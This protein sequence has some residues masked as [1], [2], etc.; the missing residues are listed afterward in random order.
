MIIN[1][2]ILFNGVNQV[3]KRMTF[4]ED[5]ENYDKFRPTYPRE[6]FREIIDYANLDLKKH[7]LEIEIGI[8]KATT[9]ILE[10]GCLVYS[11]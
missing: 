7:S 2:L 9:P 4:N 1:I 6:L 5:V 11:N 3:G 8:G 10:T